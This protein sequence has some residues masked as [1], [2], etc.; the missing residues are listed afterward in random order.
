MALI[1]LL[2]SECGLAVD[3]GAIRDVTLT[4]NSR[5]GLGQVLLAFD[6]GISP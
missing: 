3:R 5:V 6:R 4:E 1:T 2:V